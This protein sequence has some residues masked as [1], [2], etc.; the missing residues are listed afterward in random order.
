MSDLSGLDWNIDLTGAAG[1][2]P[3]KA[4]RVRVRDIVPDYEAAHSESPY[5]RPVGG[6]LGAEVTISQAT[7]DDQELILG[8][9]FALIRG[10]YYELKIWADGRGGNVFFYCETMFF[11][12]PETT[13]ELEGL[14]PQ[15]LTF[16]TFE[17]YSSFGEPQA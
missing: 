6:L 17:S 15:D 8:T 4:N 7:L 12:G 10:L 3:L 16:K 11:A 5:R 9:P 14:Q 2:L 13:L 1:T